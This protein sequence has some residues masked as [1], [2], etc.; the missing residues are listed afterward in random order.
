MAAVRA[1]HPRST[2]PSHKC[3][4]V[5]EKTSTHQY[6][7]SRTAWWSEDPLAA[8]SLMSASCLAFPWV[9]IIF[10]DAIRGNAACWSSPNQFS[11]ARPI[12]CNAAIGTI[13]CNSQWNL[14]SNEWQTK[15]SY[16]SARIH[17]KR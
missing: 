1:P 9:G 15:Q 14:R 3:R 11:T 17:L 8:H 7:L 5:E 4:T 2:Y 16:T 10:N 13:L 12:S 6:V